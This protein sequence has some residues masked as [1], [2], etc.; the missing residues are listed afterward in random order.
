MKIKNIVFDCGNVMVRFDS[1]YIVKKHVSNEEDAELLASVMFDRLYFDRLDLGTITDEEIVEAYKQRL[2]ERLH[3][4]AV[5]IYS[6]WI[7]DMPEI[8]GMADLV[9]YIKETYNA[10]VF[11]LSNISKGYAEHKD[12]MPYLKHFDKCI[13]SGV[14]GMIKPQK[15]IYEYLCKECNIRPEETLFVD[16]SE[17]NINGAKACG[18]NVY[19][20]DG[21]SEKLKKYIDEVLG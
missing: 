14:C 15:E 17:L 8:E 20:F 18:I 16:D 5:C 4:K 21:D 3:E 7:Y 2:P 11:L 9:K 1:E 19:L 13:F 6:N 10:P 12:E